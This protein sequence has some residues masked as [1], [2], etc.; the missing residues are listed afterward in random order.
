[1]SKTFLTPATAK[2]TKYPECKQFSTSLSYL[3]IERLE[4]IKTNRRNLSQKKQRKE[5]GNDLQE[6]LSKER[7]E[8]FSKQKLYLVEATEI[9]ANE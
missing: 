9:V 6:V 7:R 3:T 2:E 5:E 1:M 8:V 4:E